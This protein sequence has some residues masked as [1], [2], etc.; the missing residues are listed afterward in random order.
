MGVENEN[1]DRSQFSDMKNLSKTRKSNYLGQQ[2]HQIR[3]YLL[4]E[5]LGIVEGDA[6]LSSAR[7]AQPLNAVVEVQVI[8]VSGETLE[9]PAVNLLDSAE[10]IHRSSSS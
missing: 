1:P 7:M 4:D 10:F 2:C 8:A 5:G 6:A 3:S 9:V